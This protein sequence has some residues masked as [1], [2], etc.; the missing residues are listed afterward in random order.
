VFPPPANVT[1]ANRY[2]ESR[3]GVV[4][5]AVLR[6]DG[7]IVG[8][9]RKRTFVTASVVKAMELVAYL[10]QLDARGRS[11]S[12]AD[13]AILGP[14][15]HISDNDAA[16]VI[17]ERIGAAGLRSVARAVGMTSFSVAGNW[18]RAR[19]TAADQVRFFAALNQVTPARFRAYA[20]GLL[21]HVIAWQ[22][23]GIPEIARPDWR[24]YFKVGC[25][26]TSRGKLVHEAARLE[27]GKRTIAIAV[28]TDGNPDFPYGVE[29]IRG[30]T[31]RLL[32]IQRRAFVRLHPC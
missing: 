2:A 1:A 30:V 27:D 11:L 21:R 26:D 3:A 9:H 14:M 15:I 28:L 29:T 20:R 10:R 25:R 4:A 31:R 18:P 16:S 6:T 32:G 24:V 5:F 12:A 19:I 7:S 8:G 23:W 17:W 13:R 22:A